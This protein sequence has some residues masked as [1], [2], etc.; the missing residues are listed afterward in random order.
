MK[1]AQLEQNDKPIMEVVVVLD[2]KE[3]KHIALAMEAYAKAH[4]RSK[5]I[6]KLTEEFG[7]AS[8]FF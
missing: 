1:T 2:P 4:P 5:A 6:A 3:A 7:C 8:M